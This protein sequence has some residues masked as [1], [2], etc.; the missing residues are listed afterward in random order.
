MTIGNLRVSST[1]PHLRR[2]L[3][4]L[5]VMTLGGTSE[6]SQ[7]ETRGYVVSWFATATN[8][9]KFKENCPK[10]GNG[11]ML[12]TSIRD[13]MDIGYS[14]EK[15]VE[16][17]ND[18]VVQAN[19]EIQDKIAYRAIVAGKHV[20]AYD[21]PEAV[22]D[23]RIETVTGTLAYGFDLGGDSSRKFEDPETHERIDNQLWRAVGCM[24][25]YHAIPPTM[26]Y[27]EEVSWNVMIDSAPA[28]ILQI[29]GDDLTKDGKVT[30]TLD[31]A[32]QHLERDATDAV[33]SNAT[34][35]VDP[36]PRSHNVLPGELKHGSL[37]IQPADIYL[38]GEM[39]F[40]F[41]VALKNAHMR[42]RSDPTGKLIGYW[43]GYLEWKK[44]AYMFT[45][46]AAAGDSIGLYYALKKMADYAPDPKTGQNQFISA[47]FRME[48]LPAYLAAIDGRIVAVPASNAARD[49]SSVATNTTVD[50][51]LAKSQ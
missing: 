46:R 38:E 1:V 22:P 51:N 31:R 19:P 18:P 2:A 49:S 40:Y 44:F 26:P 28:W 4:V 11:G 47:T 7:A 33:L 43:G 30:V 32:L 37:T 12:E 20:S 45:A 16:M 50:Q 10:G 9:Q 34:Y 39:P 17:A 8:S 41:D 6:V 42:F 3:V 24:G 36:S 25:I 23:P 35:V 29:T 14:K 27:P 5:S 21:F 48:A 15:A 13:L